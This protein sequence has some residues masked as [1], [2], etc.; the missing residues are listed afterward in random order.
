MSITYFKNIFNIDNLYSI[1]YN[2]QANITKERLLY[3][4]T[5]EIVALCIL[6]IS[7]IGV[8]S[9]ALAVV[10]KHKK[11]EQINN[12]QQQ[13]KL[14]KLKK[15]FTTYE[16]I[17]FVLIT[18][19]TIV[20]AIIY[21]EETTNGVSG[22]LITVLYTLDVIIACL[23]ELLTSKQSKWSFIIYLLVEAIEIAVLIMIKARF[24]TLAVSVF[25]WAPMHIVSFI[26]WHKHPD[27]Q[28]A[29]LTV[30]RTLKWW[31]SLIM[32]AICIAWTVGIG[33]LMA[34]YGPETEFYSNE[35]IIK[36]IAYMDACVSAVGLA[37]GILLFFRFKENWIVWYISVILETIINI[38]SGQWVLLVLKVGY[39]T[40][41][42]YGYLK[43][44]K[45]I[46]SKQEQPAIATQKQITNS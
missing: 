20:L 29:E 26:N 32:I 5:F 3:M 12:P 42:T 19:A 41:T 46:K 34:A 28:K 44:T 11:Q 39:F 36:V 31:Q 33:Y 37:N 2:K 1:L 9:L 45:Y 24:A 7:F 8:L 30:V 22:I 10:I 16:I 17:W 25:F 43:W 18:I 14:N 4:T 6:G 27:K 40:N 13:K 38:I 15:Y 23:C 21:P 35:T